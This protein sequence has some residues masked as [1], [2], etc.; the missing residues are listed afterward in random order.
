MKG[1]DRELFSCNEICRCWLLIDWARSPALA[2][3][4]FREFWRYL[5][6]AIEG[7]KQPIHSLFGLLDRR[8]RER[9][10]VAL[11]DMGI[12][13]GDQLL[14]RLA[15]R[16]GVGA[17]AAQHAVECDDPGRYRFEA[18]FLGVVEIVGRGDEQAEHEGR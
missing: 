7:D 11:P 2:I 14:Q 15:G 5:S 3:R 1:Q 8:R 6:Q 4:Y 17:V 9:A 13:A 16:F 12:A 10:F 18:G